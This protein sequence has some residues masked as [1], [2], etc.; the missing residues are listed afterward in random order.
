MENIKILTA[1]G[2]C[3]EA[4]RNGTKLLSQSNKTKQNRIKP[5]VNISESCFARKLK[6]S[7]RAVLTCIMQTK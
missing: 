6:I 3:L 1:D 5:S 4:K 2:I 7:R